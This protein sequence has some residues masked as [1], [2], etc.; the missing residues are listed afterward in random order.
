MVRLLLGLLLWPLAELVVLLWIADRF[1]WQ[2]AVVIILA[3]MVL[4]AWLIRRA[5]M[6]SIRLIRGRARPSEGVESL[7]NNLFT[8][9]AG[10]LFLVPGVLSDSVAVALLIPWSRRRIQ[11]RML[12]RLRAR[13]YT[14]LGPDAPG[15]GRIIDVQV[16]KPA[17]RQGRMTN[18]K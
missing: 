14:S 2:T 11:S 6:R 8:L 4:G 5:G 16:V 15:G 9:A 1:S 12:G 17:D 18:N 10:V 13:F 7:A 3:G